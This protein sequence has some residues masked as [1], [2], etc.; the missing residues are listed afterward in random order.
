MSVGFFTAAMDLYDRGLSVIPIMLGGKRPEIPGQPPGEQTWERYMEVR[1]T[2]G[3]IEQWFGNGTERNIGVVHGP[4]SGNYVVIDVD[5]DSGI[6]SKIREEHGY[7]FAGRYVISG[8]RH[9]YHIPLQLGTLP[10]FGISH[11][12]EGDFPRGNMTWKTDNGSVNIRAQR[13]QSVV[14]PSKHASGYEYAYMNPNGADAD[15]TWLPDLDQF[16]YWLNTNF[17]PPKAEI[18]RL[19]KKRQS[20]E[21]GYTRDNGGLLKAV[22]EVW[23]T[24]RLV[25]YFDLITEEGI[26][27]Q[28]TGEN[29]VLGNGG[30]FI[31]PDR[32]KW[33]CFEQDIG[34]GPVEF[35][36]WQRD[37]HYNHENF[38]R[39]LV[40]MA[41]AA[42][43][44]LEQLLVR[45]DYQY[46]NGLITETDGDRSRWTRQYLSLMPQPVTV[47]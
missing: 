1:A 30:L 9:G 20:R 18:K 4:V 26:K 35:W 22:L 40:E 33:W 6:F 5:K 19:E 46:L 2:P 43:L 17:E 42:G 25:Q 37:G 21:T 29:K 14:P 11:T 47:T 45:S 15:I 32:L 31:K 27:K 41:W 10:D 16:I 38:R 3:E 36:A 12:A 28:R 24:W 8:S 39:Y 7:M 34:G 13:C 44:P 23:D